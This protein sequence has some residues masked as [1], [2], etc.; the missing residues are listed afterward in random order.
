MS[1]VLE[2][3]QS[4]LKWLALSTLIPALL[5]L[6]WFALR[7]WLGPVWLRKMCERAGDSPEEIASAVRDLKRD[8]RDEVGRLLRR[9]VPWRSEPPEPPVP[10]A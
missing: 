3:A 1:A 4:L 8:Q 5:C 2:H 7:I 6:F 9:P 10:T